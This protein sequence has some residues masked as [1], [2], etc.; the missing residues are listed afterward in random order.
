MSELSERDM[1]A[2]ATAVRILREAGYQIG[3]SKSAKPTDNGVE[4]KL[5]V[6]AGTRSPRFPKQADAVKT[7]AIEAPEFDYGGNLV[8][9]ESGGGGR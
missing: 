8:E 6:V 3:Q 4:F 7:A 1:E 2:V 5:D 9:S